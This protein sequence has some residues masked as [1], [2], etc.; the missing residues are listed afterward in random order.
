MSADR[1]FTTA[2]VKAL[3]IRW[4]LRELTAQEVHESAELLLDD[5]PDQDSWPGVE[6]ADPRWGPRTVIGLLANLA[7]ALY[8]PADIPALRALL[9]DEVPASVRET[10]WEA[11]RGAVDWKDRARRATSLPYYNLWHRP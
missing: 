11:Y 8:F 5:S 10:S 4:E 9:D 6:H 7:D 2:E 3:L 1:E